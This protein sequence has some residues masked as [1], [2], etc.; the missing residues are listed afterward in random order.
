MTPFIKNSY[1][2]AVKLHTELLRI[3][4]QSRQTGSRPI[5]RALRKS[6]FGNNARTNYKPY[7]TV[8]GT[9]IK[10]DDNLGH[11][12]GRNWRNGS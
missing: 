2:R 1:F 12:T 5:L 7:N 9:K 3:C 11:T 6:K 10:Y 4:H 8:A